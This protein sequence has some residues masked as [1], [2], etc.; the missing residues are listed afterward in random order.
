MPCKSTKVTLWYD[1]KKKPTGRFKFNCQGDCE[2]K[3]GEGKKAC[4]TVQYNTLPGETIFFCACAE[5]L[6]NGEVPGAP[7]DPPNE[8]NICQVVLVETVKD[9]EVTLEPACRGGC[10][11]ELK[12]E[13]KLKSSKLEVRHIRQKD[14]SVTTE[15]TK[16]FWCDCMEKKKE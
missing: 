13:C 4:T 5:E 8:D 10:P 12:Q 7:D 3:A 6:E 14:G 2:Q 9:E 15:R 16:E 1:P 11:K